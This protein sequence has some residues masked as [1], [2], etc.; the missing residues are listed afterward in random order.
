MANAERVDKVN[1][2]F[3]QIML[4][5]TL[6]GIAATLTGM[7]VDHLYGEERNNLELILKA[8]GLSL[9]GICG[10]GVP[11]ARFMAGNPYLT[12]PKAA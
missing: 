7:A 11:L 9:A 10:I 6:L 2:L 5:G 1:N 12:K 4:Y 3:A 8:G